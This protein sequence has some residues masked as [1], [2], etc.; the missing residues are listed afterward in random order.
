MN[1]IL[2]ERIEKLGQIGDVVSVKPGFARNYLL[3]QKKALRATDE[4]LAVFENQRAQIE[5]DNLERRKEAEAVAGKLDDFSIIVIRQAGESGQLYGSVNP[6]DIASGLSE[7][8]VTVDRRQVAL[9]RAIKSLGLHDVK[10]RL[11]PE[12]SVSIMVN[13]ARS[14]EEAA[15]QRKAGRMVTEAEREAAEIAAEAEIEAVIAAEAETASEEE[16]E[17]PS[18]EA[19]A[20]SAEDHEEEEQP[21][22]ASESS[23]ADEAAMGEEQKEG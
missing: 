2:L 9:E 23:S 11:H 10:L 7:A 8:G 6:R 3:P 18:E 17:L 16:A 20:A 5:A 15:Q 13:V 22:A 21:A 4:N 12:V 19:E 14:E 1:V